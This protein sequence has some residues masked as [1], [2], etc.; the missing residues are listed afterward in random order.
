MANLPDIRRE[1][2]EDDIAK[3]IVLKLKTESLDSQDYRT[4]ANRVVSEIF[5]DWETDPRIRFLVID[6]W[7]ER[8]F[9][10][11]DINYHDY[12]FNTA[13]KDKTILPVFVLRQHGR[14]KDWV[15]IRWPKEDEHLAAQLA[16]LHR[17]NG[18]DAPPFLEDHTIRLFHA[19]PRNLS[20]E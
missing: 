4:S 2:L 19:N 16:D 12:D 17:V 5:P 1:I 18:F 6:V 11:I 8:T 9:I 13:H 10:V 14:R 3:R 20:S 7:S 15:L